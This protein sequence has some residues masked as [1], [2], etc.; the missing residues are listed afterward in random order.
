MRPNLLEF[1]ARQIFRCYFVILATAK[2]MSTSIGPKQLASLHFDQPKAFFSKACTPI[3][4]WLH[5]KRHAP[6]AF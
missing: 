2:G 6:L 4:A 1:V 5:A 3:L